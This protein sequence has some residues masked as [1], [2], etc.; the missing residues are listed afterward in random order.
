MLKSLGFILNWV[1]TWK[2]LIILSR[3]EKKKWAGGRSDSSPC[4]SFVW[5][6]CWALESIVE[7]AKVNPAFRS[8]PCGLRGEPPGRQAQSASFMPPLLFKA[9]LLLLKEL[10]HC[11]ETS[12]ERT[13]THFFKEAFCNHGF[14]L[15][16]HV[17][18][19]LKSFSEWPRIFAKLSS[20]EEKASL[21]F[22]FAIVFKI[23]SFGFSTSF[24]S[25]S[26][27][28]WMKAL[29]WWSTA[30]GRRWST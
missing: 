30:Q 13:E 27:Q 22:F 16:H 29:A 6:P 7:V 11:W 2:F 5:A 19:P 21:V 24:A 14:H 3:S 23:R 25:F 26:F 15:T 17:G 9:F 8:L 1:L 20:L 18:Y 12:I 28:V 4:A 10:Q